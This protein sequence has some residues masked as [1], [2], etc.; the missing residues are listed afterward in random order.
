MISRSTL[1]KIVLVF[2]VVQV[3]LYE[4]GAFS[5][6]FKK[7][8]STN[9]DI[10]FEKSNWYDDTEDTAGTENTIA[11]KANNTSFSKPQ[12]TNQD[13]DSKKSN[14]HETTNT[15]WTKN[16]GI[17][18]VKTHK[19]V[20]SREFD[21]KLLHPKKQTELWIRIS[22][23]F[24]VRRV[25]YLDLRDKGSVKIHLI[26]MKDRA[27]ADPHIYMRLYYKDTSKKGPS[28]CQTT[29]LENYS[30]SGMDDFKRH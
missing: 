2:L 5:A 19:V 7:P 22:G 10:E 29:E 23:A 24:I 18:K 16:T 26:G 21:D 20:S 17:S 8:R 3:L 30:Q 28:N 11:S 14:L 6:L 12:S 15:G 4:I 25:G 1:V 9:R 27:T 13:Y